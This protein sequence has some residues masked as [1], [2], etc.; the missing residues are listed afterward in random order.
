MESWHCGPGQG[1]H[2]CHTPACWSLAPGPHWKSGLPVCQCLPS[3]EHAC[4]R[5]LPE[6]LLPASAAEEEEAV[7]RAGLLGERSMEAGGRRPA[8]EARLTEPG[9][10]FLHFPPDSA[11]RSSPCHPNPPSACVPHLLC[12][13]QGPRESPGRPRWFGPPGLL[14]PFAELWAFYT[15]GSSSV[16]VLGNLLVLPAW[17]AACAASQAANRWPTPTE[18]SDWN[19]T[20]PA[21]LL[22]LRVALH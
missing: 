6:P 1:A 15:A 13:A 11:P 22:P 20:S 8:G 18:P 7:G 17:S 3:E 10:Q 21:H 9:P 12:L 5:G 2:L 16:A 4:C 19:V 14:T